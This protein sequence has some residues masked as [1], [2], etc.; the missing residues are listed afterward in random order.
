[1]DDATYPKSA[2]DICTGDY[3]VI[4]KRPCK[5]LSV[6]TYQSTS[7]DNMC[8]FVATDIFNGAVRN[9]GVPVSHQC[10]VPRVKITN[11]KLK[12]SDMHGKDRADLKLPTDDTV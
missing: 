11:Y 12:L 2:G 8:A 10:D 7:N 5:V 9:Y 1:M 3:I 6:F 4:D